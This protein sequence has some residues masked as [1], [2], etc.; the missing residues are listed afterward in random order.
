L[1]KGGFLVRL[2]DQHIRTTQQPKTSICAADKV[3]QNIRRKTRQ[4]CS[5]ERKIAGLAVAQDDQPGWRDAF[6]ENLIAQDYG[7]KRL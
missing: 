7:R 5:A 1:N 3:V 4:T 6:G 2:F